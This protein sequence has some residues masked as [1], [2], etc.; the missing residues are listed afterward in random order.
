MRKLM[1]I[2]L[3]LV[4]PLTAR[5]LNSSA[6][7]AVE[8]WLIAA[9]VGTPARHRNLVLYPVTLPSRKLPDYHTLDQ[10]LALGKLVIGETNESGTVNELKI[11][12]R[13]SEP[14]F[15]MAGEILQGAKQDRVLQDDLWLPANSGRTSVA[16]YCVEHGRWDYQTKTF[17][18]SRPIAANLEVRSTARETND[19]GAV[20]SSVEKTQTAA[21]YKDSSNLGKTYDD[22]AVKER[23]AGYKEALSTFAREN[24]E[25]RGVVVQVG[26]RILAVDLFA[27][28]A[29]F[30]MKFNKLLPSYALEAAN[31]GGS[32]AAID[33]DQAL[34]FL[35]RTAGAD[36][37]S[38]K[39]PGDGKLLLASGGE[40][41]GSA[42]VLDQVVVHL[43]AFPRRGKSTIKPD[44]PIIRDY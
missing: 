43:E 1:L 27:D 4:T 33:T 23:I 16:V 39:T 28:R 31:T 18:K 13:G 24:P 8:N 19:Q 3:L 7:L 11:E 2:L 36:W 34:R 5:E 20:W 6:Q 26:D 30:V 14:V 38:K 44:R 35:R 41:S 42:L 12:N 32:S 21:G 15:I 10:A 37:T 29:G 22:P 25:A 17:E 40:L 9:R